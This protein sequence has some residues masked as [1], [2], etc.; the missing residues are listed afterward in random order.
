MKERLMQKVSETGYYMTEYVE[1][2]DSK[3]CDALIAFFAH[4]GALSVLDMGCGVKCQYVSQMAEAGVPITGL[5]GNPTMSGPN[6]IVHDL[7]ER[8]PLKC[9]W[10]MCLEVGEHVPQKF[11][12][13]L[14]DNITEA[15]KS[16]LVLS[17]A[18]PKQPGYHHVNCRENEYIIKQVEKRGLRW[19]PEDS[20]ILREAAGLWWFKNTLM[21]FERVI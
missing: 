7:T 8:I 19:L 20:E 11:E 10:G 21:V 12:S 5:D 3:L 9:D 4:R 2:H 1:K 6:V 17:W 14:L 18:I 13:Q 15:C 16:G